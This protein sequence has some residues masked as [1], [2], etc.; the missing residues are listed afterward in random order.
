MRGERARVRLSR[1]HLAI[2]HDRKIISQCCSSRVNDVEMRVYGKIEKSRKNQVCWGHL[3]LVGRTRNSI[4]DKANAEMP[5]H[6]RIFVIKRV[7]FK[8]G[9]YLLC[10]TYSK[11][12]LFAW[13]R[14]TWSGSGKCKL[15]N[16]KFTCFLQKNFYIKLC[17][18]RMIYLSVIP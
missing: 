8:L 11:I 9:S 15:L 13:N 18:K 4:F 1:N 6:Q 16:S 10:F 2:P 5:E 7:L 12:V 14:D 17:S 3:A